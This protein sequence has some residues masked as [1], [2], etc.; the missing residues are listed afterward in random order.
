[1]SLGRTALALELPAVG[2]ADLFLAP[3]LWLR[4]LGAGPAGGAMGVEEWKDFDLAAGLD[5]VGRPLPSEEAGGAPVKMLAAPA[6]DR[7]DPGVW[8]AVGWL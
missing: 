4:D 1:M 7:P 3:E 6:L 5:P 8:P 2:G